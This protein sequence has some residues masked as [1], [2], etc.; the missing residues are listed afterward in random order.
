M[1]KV[2]K[3]VK[4]YTANIY[5]GFQEGYDGKIHTIEEAINIAQEYCNSAGYGLTVTP[6]TFIYKDGREDGCIIGLINY[7]RFPTVPE[8]IQH[9]AFRLADIFL[10]E[11]KQNRIS[12]VCEDI[13]FM[14][15][16]EEE[17][18]S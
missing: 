15:E 13:T 5:V 2:A 11:F 16:Q 12:F 8:V 17:Y 10:E 1:K 18:G 7:P 9:H 6:T 4:S 14:V 3:T